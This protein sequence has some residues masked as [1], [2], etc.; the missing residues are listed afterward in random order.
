MIFW[1]RKVPCLFNKYVVYIFRLSSE[2]ILQH[3]RYPKAFGSFPASSVVETRAGNLLM[4]PTL[5][6]PILVAPTTLFWQL[7][8]LLMIKASSTKKVINSYPVLIQLRNISFVKVFC[9]ILKVQRWPHIKKKIVPTNSRSCSQSCLRLFSTG[10]KV[11]KSTLEI[12]QWSQ[13]SWGGARPWK[14]NQTCCIYNIYV[15]NIKTCTVPTYSI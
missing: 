8:L 13:G 15:Y 4:G 6:H 12:I 11:L 9:K 7:W 14:H 1:G 3:T 10:C 5:G 2:T